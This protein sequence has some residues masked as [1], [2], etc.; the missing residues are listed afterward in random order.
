MT[1]GRSGQPRAVTVSNLYSNKQ[2]T[3]SKQQEKTIQIEQVSKI[4]VV[5][6]GLV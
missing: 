1:K 4:N 6:N 3:H 2:E 5:P